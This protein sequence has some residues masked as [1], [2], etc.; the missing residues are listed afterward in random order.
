MRR[1]DTAVELIETNFCD[2]GTD[3]GHLLV[4]KCESDRTI[5]GIGIDLNEGPLNNAKQNIIRANLSDRINLFL[6]NGLNEI[7][8]E[9]LV[10]YETY[11]IM[12]L[13]GNLIIEILTKDL[14]IKEFENILVQANNNTD[15]VYEFM[16]S[17]NYQVASTRFVEDMGIIYIVS[18]FKKNNFEKFKNKYLYESKDFDL[19]IKYFNK[20]IIYYE[21]LLNKIPQAHSNA[22]KIQTKI[23]KIEKEKERIHEVK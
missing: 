6:S 21:K 14:K 18:L 15:K 8:P 10:D 11:S 22:I 17:I 23:L 5:R 4:K 3:H 9:L 13:G 1:I 2:I 19:A 12:G 7:S 16:Q 20:D